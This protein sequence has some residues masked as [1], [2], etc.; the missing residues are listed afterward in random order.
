VLTFK[1]CNR[2]HEAEIDCIEGIPKKQWRKIL[3]KNILSD[4]IEKKNN[5]EKKEKIDMS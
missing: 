2:D 4:E 5:L 3:N 1:T